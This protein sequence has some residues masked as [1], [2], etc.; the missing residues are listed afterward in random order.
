MQDACGRLI[1]QQPDP[2][3]VHR[4]ERQ[5]DAHGCAVRELEGRHA[6]EP[7][8][9]PVAMIQRPGLAGLERIAALE[10][11]PCM[12]FGRAHD[13]RPGG[14]HRACADRCAIPLEG[15]EERRILQKGD[16]DG[17]AEPVAPRRIGERA[18]ERAVAHHRIGRCER[19]GEV[20]L[21]LAVHAVL[22]PHGAVVLGKHR[23]RHAHVPHAAVRDRGAKADDIEHGPAADGQHHAVA[24]DAQVFDGI[25]HGLD[26][27]RI[28]LARLTARHRLDPDELGQPGVRLQVP[29]EVVRHLRPRSRHAGIDE[30]GHPDR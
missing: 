21:P 12:Q 25:Q 24:I 19:A 30:G 23:R 27:R 15:C 28:V 4:V 7:V 2:P 17:L 5:A 1:S 6:L 29:R 3:R 8:C 13:D 14:L 18:Q 20:L 9:D 10:D 22:H 11:V 26:A 16:L